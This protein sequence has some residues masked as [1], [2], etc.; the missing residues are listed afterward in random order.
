VLSHIQWCRQ[1]LE[2]LQQQCDTMAAQT[3]SDSGEKKALQEEI[4]DL[5]FKLVMAGSEAEGVPESTLSEWQE[6]KERMQRELKAAQQQYAA[7]KAQQGADEVSEGPSAVSLDMGKLREVESQL[8]DSKWQVSQLTA[9]CTELQREVEALRSDRPAQEPEEAGREAGGGV[10]GA[11]EEAG[12]GAQEVADGWGMSEEWGAWDEQEG[13]QELE[14]VEREGQRGGAL[15]AA[16][17]ARRGDEWNRKADKVPGSEALSNGS[18]ASQAAAQLSSHRKVV[19]SLS[20]LLRSN[21]G[22]AQ[23]LVVVQE[24][25]KLL[26]QH[27]VPLD[28]GG[29]R[30]GAV[31]TAPPERRSDGGAPPDSGTLMHAPRLP[32]RGSIIIAVLPG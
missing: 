1:T 16:A 10:S 2:E 26:A 27:G 25:L 7:L 6:V 14:A 22:P 29:A 3:K 12:R 32:A 30:E 23:D 8:E 11:A 18:A 9:R 31:A 28:T 19:E 13:A 21:E 24:V 20:G 17:D 15:A 4:T 5:R